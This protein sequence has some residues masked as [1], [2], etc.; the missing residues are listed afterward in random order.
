[1]KIKFINLLFIIS[2]ALYI[3][4]CSVNNIWCFFD[5]VNIFIHELGHIVFMPFGQ[6]IYIAGGSIFQTIIPLLLFFYFLQKRDYY[7][8]SFVLLWLGQSIVNTSVYIKDA[9]VMNLYLIGGNIHDWN[10]LLTNINLLEKSIFL[11]DAIYYIG[12]SIVVIGFLCG[13]IASVK[14][15]NNKSLS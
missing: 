11:G 14:N 9:Q 7:A 4:Y 1:M 15:Y 6:F 3:L 2:I 8:S 12:I 5:W 13:I 10:Y